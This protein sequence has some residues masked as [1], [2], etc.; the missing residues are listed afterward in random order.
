MVENAGA[1][2]ASVMRQLPW[3]RGA[4]S[5]DNRGNRSSDDN[6]SGLTHDGRTYSYDGR[7]NVI[8]VRGE[9]YNG[10]GWHYYQ[11]ASSFDAR[12][13][14]VFKSFFDE[15]TSK[16]ATW[17]FYYDALNRLAEVRYTPDTSASSTYTVFQLVWLE[18]RLVLYWQID[19]PS[20]TTSKRYVATDET[21]RP[22][23][24][25]TWPSSGNAARA[26]ATAPDAWGYDKNSVG[27]TIYQPMLF[28]GQYRDDETV[29]LWD[30]H[31]TVARPG[32][33]LNGFRTYDAFVGG[34]LQVDPL[35]DSTRSSYVYVDSNPVGHADPTGRMI[36]NKTIGDMLCESVE[37][38]PLCCQLINDTYGGLAACSGGDY[39]GGSGPSGGGRPDYGD[40]KPCAAKEQKQKYWCSM[41]DEP[42]APK[43][44]QAPRSYDISNDIT[45]H[46]FS[47]LPQPPALSGVGDTQVTVLFSEE[48]C[49]TR[50]G[51]CNPGPGR[52]NACIQCDAATTELH[53]CLSAIEDAP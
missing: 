12:N 34:Y 23:D 37:D 13:R 21:G 48:E 28:A 40:P 25:W 15:S 39:P 52:T 33:V 3:H 16:M 36:A 19:Y 7:R 50:P 41:C 29:S 10:G 53:D 51:G 38:K 22:L 17:F 20:A 4:Y 49:N 9:Y 32:V 43:P 14:R 27:Q 8:N 30:D 35:V 6:T 5:Y 26:W 45:T 47:G 2:A 18:D 46:V 31:A 11:V 42:T 44:R 24:M 1:Q